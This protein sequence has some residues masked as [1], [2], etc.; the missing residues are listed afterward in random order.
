[1]AANTEYN[2]ISIHNFKLDIL[3]TFMLALF[4]FV[5]SSLTLIYVEVIANIQC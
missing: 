4:V 5:T 1:M 2:Y 3:P